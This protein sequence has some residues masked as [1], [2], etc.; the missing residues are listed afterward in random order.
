MKLRKYVKL[1]SF[2]MLFSAILG[3]CVSAD[4]NQVISV[5]QG[6]SYQNSFHNVFKSFVKF[7]TAYDIAVKSV[8]PEVPKML[9]FCE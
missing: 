2:V 3:L 6:K 9:K 1:L 4:G 8:L 5:S 7:L